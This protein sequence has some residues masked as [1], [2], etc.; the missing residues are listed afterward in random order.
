MALGPSGRSGASR[1]RDSA[2]R[3]LN[4]RAAVTECTV[5]VRLGS[6]SSPG[7]DADTNV[8]SSRPPMMV[9]SKSP[10]GGSGVGVW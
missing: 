7:C 5:L 8:P 4:S 10:A 2:S 3:S 9:A 1:I 6:R